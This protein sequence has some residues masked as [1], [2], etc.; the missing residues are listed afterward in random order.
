MFLY[1]KTKATKLA[2]YTCFIYRE[3]DYIVKVCPKYKAILVLLELLV[4]K[5]IKI[6]EENNNA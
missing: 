2:K 1:Y 3:P 6:K 5:V 4:D